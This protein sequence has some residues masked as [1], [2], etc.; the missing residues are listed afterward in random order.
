[1]CTG[2]AALSFAIPVGINLATLPRASVE[3]ATF[4]ISERDWRWSTRRVV[5]L[6]ESPAALAKSL[7]LSSRLGASERCMIK[8]YSL[9]LRPVPWIR[10]ESICRGRSLRMRAME[11][12]RAS[13]VGESGSALATG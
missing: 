9:A 11:R 4:E 8:V 1:M 12:H 7:I 6:A 10:S 5:R 3:L 2:H 13:S